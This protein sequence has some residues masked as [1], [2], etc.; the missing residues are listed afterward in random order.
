MAHCIM[1]CPA[2]SLCCIAPGMPVTPKSRWPTIG[3]GHGM[4]NINN[5]LERTL[6]WDTGDF[7]FITKT[8][9]SHYVTLMHLDYP[10]KI[11]R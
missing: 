9:L 8:G 10:F 11:W 6:A 5:A 7:H 1:L 2:G 3:G 4:G